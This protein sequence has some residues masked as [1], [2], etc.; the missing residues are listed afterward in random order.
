MLKLSKGALHKISSGFLSYEFFEAK[1]DLI[2]DIGASLIN[3]FGFK[4]QFTPAVGLDSIFWDFCRDDVKL[5]VGWD[6]WSGCFIM[7]NCKKGDEFIAQYQIY[8]ENLLTN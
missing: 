4:E 6:I 5:T 1:E 2:Y 8:V 7:S 3:Y